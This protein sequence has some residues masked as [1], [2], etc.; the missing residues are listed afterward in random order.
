MR[1]RPCD[2]FAHPLDD[3]LRARSVAELDALAR[4]SQHSTSI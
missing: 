1:R 4:C 3:V 2:T